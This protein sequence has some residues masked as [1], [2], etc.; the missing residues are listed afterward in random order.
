MT[1]PLISVVTISFNQKQYLRQTIESVLAQKSD[2]IEFIV[3]DAG[4]TDGSQELIAS[5]G[6]RIDCVIS[7]PDQ[8]PSDG[9]NKG[10]ARATGRVGYFLNSD[11]FLMPHA[12]EIMRK[13]WTRQRRA[14]ILLCSSWMV[15][16]QGKPLR[17]LRA[18]TDTI[19][20]LL[21]GSGTMVQQGLSFRLDSFRRIKGFN[22][23]NRT[24]WD[25]EL[26]CELLRDG[27]K[28]EILSERIG[29]FRMH[30]NSLSGGVAGIKHFA[31]YRADHARLMQ[32]FGVEGGGPK[33]F[34][35]HLKSPMLL[36]DRLMPWFMRRRFVADCKQ[37]EH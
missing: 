6:R 13:Y 19:E 12:V 7:E 34:L 11:D 3:V 31:K 32:E 29:A 16:Y 35:R 18:T 15:D 4:S 30:E 20:G 37:Y 33:N 36:I 5:Y 14:D 17:E 21:N 22:V 2:D 26:L 25:L 27:A 23:E 10:F 1:Q 8:G 9:L 28:A 24:C